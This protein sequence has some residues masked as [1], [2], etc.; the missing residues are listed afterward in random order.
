MESD[1]RTE[2]IDDPIMFTQAG[3]WV[4]SKEPKRESRS[5]YEAPRG[6]FSQP[7]RQTAEDLRLIGKIYKE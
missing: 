6:N 3:G 5:L 4:L 7:P 2:K 1:A